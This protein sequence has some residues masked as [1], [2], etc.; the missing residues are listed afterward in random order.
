MCQPFNGC[1]RE[2]DE[3]GPAATHPCQK[4]EGDPLS[5]NN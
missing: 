4:S 2:E 1:G 5:S 3:N